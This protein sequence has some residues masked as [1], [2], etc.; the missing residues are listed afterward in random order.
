[1]IQAERSIGEEIK[2]VE[3]IRAISGAATTYNSPAYVDRLGYDSAVLVVTAGAATGT[4]DSF[5]VNAKV[6]EEDVSSAGSLVD[7][8]GAAITQMTA[9]GKATI[10]FSLRP[11]KRY[12]N[13]ALT[14]TMLNGSSPKIPVSAVLV[15]GGA[16]IN[17]AA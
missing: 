12:L 7:I 3:A 5:T 2:C 1:M 10:A 8:T 9:A 4:P 17:P 11:Q 13:V 15:L 16:V 14:I 6:Q